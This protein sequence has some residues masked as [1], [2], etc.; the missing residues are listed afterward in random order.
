MFSIVAVPT[1]IPTNI[2]GGFLF[3]HALFSI[4]YLMMAVLTVVW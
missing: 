2:V 4:Y 1:Y 3:L